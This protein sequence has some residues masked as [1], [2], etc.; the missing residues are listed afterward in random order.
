MIIGIGGV[1]RAGKST[2]AEKLKVH[3]EKAGKSVDIF[4]QD[5][6]VKPKISIPFH[7]F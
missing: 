1:S 6:Y 2:L 3:L 5:E 4:C 7:V